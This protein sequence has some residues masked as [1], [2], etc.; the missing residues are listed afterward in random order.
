[1]YV[2]HN[3]TSVFYH[4]STRFDRLIRLAEQIYDAAEM[5]TVQLLD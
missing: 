4:K 2:R 5:R 1:M 3:F